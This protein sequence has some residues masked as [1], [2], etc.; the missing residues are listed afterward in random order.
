M[1]TQEIDVIDFLNLLARTYQA[2]CLVTAHHADDQLETQIHS[3][4]YQNTLVD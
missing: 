3:L 2:D 1:N 4:L